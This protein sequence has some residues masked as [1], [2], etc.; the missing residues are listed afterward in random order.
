VDNGVNVQKATP[1]QVTAADTRLLRVPVD[2]VALPMASLEDSE[3][4]VLAIISSVITPIENDVSGAAASAAAAA[5][6]AAA[7]AA[8]E[9][10]ADADA[11]AAAADAAAADADR[12]LAEA[13][14]AAAQLAEAGAEDARDAAF[15]AITADAIY[16]EATLAA[17]ITAGLAAVAEGESFYATGLD[18]NYIGLYTDVAGVAD[19]QTRIA[20]P[21]ALDEAVALAEAW[22]EGT[23]PGGPGTRSAREWAE[24]VIAPVDLIGS[25]TLTADDDKRVILVNIPA[26]GP[27]AVATV[28]IPSDSVDDLPA[29]TTFA[30]VRTGGAAIRFVPDEAGEA[31]IN[32]P[33]EGYG[34][35]TQNADARI[36]KGNNPN[37]WW[38][39]GAA[40][41]AVPDP[42]PL[43][44]SHEIV[45][46]VSDF[47][48]LFQ[49]TAG[50][51]PV[52][53]VGDDVCYV[54]NKGTL[55]G[56]F[57]APSGARGYTLELIDGTYML[58]RAAS[59][60]CLR[61]S[62]ATGVV[63]LS[64][65]DL[66][67]GYK[68]LTH[69]TDAGIVTFRSAGT[70]DVNRNDG[71][72]FCM[73]AN[74]WDL[75]WRMGN[76]PAIPN[77]AGLM[78]K[79]PHVV[80]LYKPG[81]ADPAI[82]SVD[83]SQDAAGTTNAS[84]TVTSLGVMGGDLVLG[85]RQANDADGVGQFGNVA[86]ACVVGGGAILTTDQRN[87]TRAWAESK[88]YGTVPHYPALTT[89]AE[90]DAARASLIDDVFGGPIPTSLGTIAVD[91]SPPITGLTNLL[92]VE[93]LTPDSYALRPRVFTPNSAR[94]DVVVL[95]W[96]GHATVMGSYNISTLVQQC[97]TANVVAVDMV[98]PNGANDY[99]SGS[100]AQHLAATPSYADWV[101]P[102]SIAINRML[103]RYPGAEIIM[104][105]ISGGAWATLLCAA[106]DDR[107]TKNIGVSG[108]LPEHIHLNRD[109]EQWLDQT[110]DFGYMDFALMSAS[111]GRKCIL[112]LHEG[113]TVGF[114]EVVYDKRP[115]A[116]PVL[117][118]MATAL[119]GEFEISW[120]NYA[121]HNYSTADRALVI[122]E[123]P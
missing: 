96:E 6:S 100:P 56:A 9:T 83:N 52:T 24:E 59:D 73:G 78:G 10:A 12:I 72:F 70:T 113:D 103:V 93:K 35:A 49:D 106:V 63:D 123:L 61:L 54:A 45:M 104:T 87:T 18:V 1:A 68:V 80:E 77:A 55:G 60:S 69:L 108:W 117:T 67:V 95:I 112:R 88:T 27:D 44:V 107:I 29:G 42:V 31:I 118:T 74:K 43:T 46:D 19:E 76:P 25:R 75:T 4:K 37:E 16:V 57:I 102:A 33:V 85:A 64:E 41:T 109:F 99:T 110:L 92:S 3:G 58:V 86:F 20:K 62:T 111:D 36:T 38:V 81:N 47:N 97:L 90:V 34:L 115:D 119:G 50:T 30:P 122:S 48:T 79:Y 94:T 98:L 28:A 23:E 8:S 15:A 101:G 40:M 91:G 53:A 22:A 66:F 82:L 17:A 71:A 5:A 13:A 105:G 89:Q 39:Y 120:E 11:D 121:P 114:G 7:A 32:L 14:R 21:E 116:A 65:L 2:E 84:A 51:I 26:P